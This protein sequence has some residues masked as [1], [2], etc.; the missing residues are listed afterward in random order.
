MAER[1][2][3]DPLLPPGAAGLD[4]LRLMEVPFVP[5]IRLHLAEDS[6]VLRARLEAEAGQPVPPPYWADAWVGG[7]AVA[8]YLRE[9]PETVAGRRVLDIAAGSGL[10]AVAAAQ[11]GALSVTAND[12]D[13]YSL[14]VIALNAKANGVNVTVQRGDLLDGDGGD[15]EV[16]LAGDVFY[17]APMAGRMLAF[18][19][20]VAARGARVIV[21]DPGRAHVPHDRLALLA[22]YDVS[23]VGAPED[24]EIST[25][26]V[27]GLKD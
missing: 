5:G 17:D 6:I 19:E 24:S 8:R 22:R 9:H 14:A 21:G 25:A 11:A 15:A 16:V 4:Q 12:I 3:L 23:M 18:L 26:Y 13:P 2:I 20:R 10:V 7:Q 1:T 27:H